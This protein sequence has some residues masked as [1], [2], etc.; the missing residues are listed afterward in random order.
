V[1]D[2]VQERG[3]IYAGLAALAVLAHLRRERWLRSLDLRFFR[4]QYNA[5][6][7]LRSTLEQVRAATNLAGVA[8]V[9]VKQIHAAMH[10]AFCA[11]LERRPMD[12]TYSVVSIFPEGVSP[13]VLRLQ[14]EV[15]EVAKLVAKP[16]QLSTQDGWLGRELPAAD[17]ES[18]ASSG[19]DLLAPVHASGRDAF[20]AL[21]KKRSEEP[22]TSD[23]VRLIEDL[24]I[25]LALLPSR[26]VLDAADASSKECP[27]CAQCYDLTDELCRRDG[28]SLVTNSFPRCFLGRFRLEFRIGRG[29]MGLVYEATDMQ[30][31]R[32]IAVKLILEDS[33]KDSAAL[34]RFRREA[35]VLASFQHSNVVTLFDAGV[36]SGGHPFLVMERL[37]GLTLREELNARTRLPAGEVRT[38][39]QQLCAA[40]LSAHRRTL[41][42]QDLKP[43]NIF[44]CD[45]DASRLVKILDFGLA[46]LL[47]ETSNLTQSTSFSTRARQILGT[48][49]YMA[50]ELLLGA[51]AERGSDIWSL[52]IVTYEM[53]TG[54]RPSFA[55]DGGL[56]DSSAEGLHGYW[57]GFFNWSLAPE[58]S[59]RPERVDAFLERF[60]QSAVNVLAPRSS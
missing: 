59:Q 60:E 45:D 13:P 39:V 3:W 18:L 32:K 51:K 8:P 15:V 12:T 29:G 36:A 56:I 48:P 9:V 47:M 1:D 53:F 7:I 21:G 50:P 27:V 23:D 54:Q 25:S 40:L 35:H 14:S 41:I 10:P 44:L 43:E 31:Q 26:S 57:S 2:I 52:A 55:R 42:H 17:V 24:A 58:P 37:N 16:L 33:I 6:D 28:S 20:I 46:K 49:A 11:V 4:E 30:L 19:V 34:D 22:Y 38:I 5:Q